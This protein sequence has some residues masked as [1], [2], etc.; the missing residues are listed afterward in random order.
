MTTAGYGITN[1][2]WPEE[3]KFSDEVNSF[4]KTWAGCYP[5]VIFSFPSHYKMFGDSAVS[6]LI[7]V[8]DYTLSMCQMNLIYLPFSPEGDITDPPHLV[9]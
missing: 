2:L 4:Y 3:G 1:Y 9:S 8:T 6:C 5:S 7:T